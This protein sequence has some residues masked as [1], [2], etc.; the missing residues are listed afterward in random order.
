MGRVKANLYAIAA[1]SPARLSTMPRPH[2][3][4]RLDGELTALRAAG[5]DVLVSLLTLGECIEAGLTGEGSAAG[6][7]GME[8]HHF[9]IGDFGVPDR[10]EIEPLLDLLTKRLVDG[11]HVAVHCYA[12]IGRASVVA[13]ALLVRLGVPADQV[14]EII[15]TARGLRVPETERQRG[16]LTAGTTLQAEPGRPD[17]TG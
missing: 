13:G 17:L 3:G 5:V 15:S 8:F 10:T 4:S 14:W 7:V 16:W 6:R 2:G 9:P 1:P 12:G 11:A